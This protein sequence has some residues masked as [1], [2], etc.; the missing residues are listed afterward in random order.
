MELRLRFI[1][2]CFWKIFP[3]QIKTR[4]NKKDGKEWCNMEKEMKNRKFL[5][6]LRL[7]L[8][9]QKA[10]WNE[11]WTEGEWIEFF[12]LCEE[13]QVL[14][15]IYDTV[16]T[17]P[18]FQ[19]LQQGTVQ[20]IKSRMLRK[21]MIQTMK[22]E[23]FLVLYRKLAD[24]GVTPLVVKGI[25]CR[26][27][28]RD[29]D[30][31]TS[32]DEDLLI[33]R[34]QF[35]KC[36]E[37]FTENGLLC[38]NSEENIWEAGEVPYVKKNSA[39][40]IEL[41]KELFPSESDA[42]GDFNSVFDEVFEKKISCQINGMEV[43]TLSPTDHLL[44]LLL[45]AFK[46]FLHSGFGIRQVCDIVMFANT[47]GSQIDWE[48]VLEKCR[49]FHGDL[50]AASLFD[51][52]EKEL[53]FDREKACYP[54]SWISL[55]ADGKDLLEDLLDAGVFGDATMSRK[56]SSNMTLQAVTDDKKGQTAKA[57]LMHSLFP[58]REYMER[59]YT[60]IKRHPF[61][62]PVAWVQRIFHYIRETGKI[63]ENSA[64]ESVQIGNKR[65]GLLKKY[66]IIQ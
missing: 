21:V 2:G 54:E 26:N 9:G 20:M 65:I 48:E 4:Q 57:S 53:D 64:V 12:K 58:E 22:T 62:L 60:Y 61:L 6:A 43:F 1:S 38:P 59:T 31:R 17:C 35:S 27:L 46:H 34:E 10:N 37:I 18:A 19:T 30:Y 49:R 16:Y 41:H 56:H 52:G 36:H 33:P 47:Y 29:P 44:Y 63:S 8:A 3:Q 13:Q 14:P 42:Y 55:E 23:E 32:S 66:K 7:Y 24:Q 5:E 51:I 11:T 25:I 50:F 40:Y 28:Y 39:L 45:H 15:M